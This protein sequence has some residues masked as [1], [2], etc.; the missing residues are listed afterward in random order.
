MF[1]FI[2]KNEWVIKIDC[3]YVYDVKKFYESFYIF[4]SIKEVVMYLRINFVV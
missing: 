2:F 3:D 4:K 1:F